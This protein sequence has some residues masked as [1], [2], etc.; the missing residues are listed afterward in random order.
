MKTTYVLATVAF[1]SMGSQVMA[2]E[3]PVDLGKKV[4]AKCGA[5]HAVGPN[6][7]K[8]TG[9]HLNGLVGRKPASVE[10]YNYTPSAVEHAKSH[11]AWTADDVKKY[12]A[13]P[14]AYNGVVKMPKQ[15][16]SDAE[17]TNLMAYLATF[18]ADGSAAQ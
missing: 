6:P 18:K 14:K 12:I 1:L 7:A 9:P 8:K 17:F 16:V 2:Q 10:G 11:E 3:T 13:D 4:F 5:C 15:N